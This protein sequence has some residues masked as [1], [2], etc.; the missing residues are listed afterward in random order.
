MSSISLSTQGRV[1]PRQCSPLAPKSACAFWAMPRTPCSLFKSAGKFCS[2]FCWSSSCFARSLAA[3]T[4]PACSTGA[5]LT[6]GPC[7]ILGLTPGCGPCG[8]LGFTPGCGPCCI[9][10]LTPGCGPCGILGLTPGC[11][12]CGILGL[13]PGCGPCGILGLTPGCGPCGMLGLT[14]GCGPCGILGLMPG[15]GPC[16][17]DVFTALSISRPCSGPYLVIMSCSSGVKP[18]VALLAC[19]GPVVPAAT[20]ASIGTSLFCPSLYVAMWLEF[21][22]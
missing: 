16:P 20:P 21:S 8:I 13:T 14:P 18:A 6:I 19:N 15:C 11:G 1:P 22:A 4:A 2:S 5:A 7:V 10:G 3:S 9:L 17:R 12:P